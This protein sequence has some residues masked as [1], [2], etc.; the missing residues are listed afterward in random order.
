MEG[1]P[2]SSTTAGGRACARRC[3][4][5]R[6]HR[7]VPSSLLPQLAQV[8]GI[9]GCHLGDTVVAVRLFGSA[10]Q[11]G[12]KPSS[13]IDLLVTVR[14]A[15]DAS[16]RHA[17]LVDLLSAS[18]PPGTCA[19]LR[20]LEL[21]VVAHDRIVPWRH[22]A[23]R[24][25]Q[26]GEWLRADIATGRFEPPMPDHDLAILLRQVREHGIALVGPG[27]VDLVAPVPDADI[28]RALQDTIAQWNTPDDWAGDERNIVL[29]LA[30]IRYTAATGRIAS[31]DVAADWLLPLLDARHRP[32]LATARAAYLGR[33]GDT[34]ASHPDAVAAY[35][36]HVRTEVAH[37]LDAGIGALARPQQE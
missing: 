35:I 23:R 15:P 1:S 13:D 11:G 3:Y 33:G 8:R 4:D 19:T 9:V 32:V 21:T 18:A 25:L 12:L 5:A 37:M 16:V 30:R 6:V 29:A 36:A 17:L 2:A 34:L 27:P 24:E 7:H 14:A 26:F 22:P 10:V 28:A 31:K 20:P